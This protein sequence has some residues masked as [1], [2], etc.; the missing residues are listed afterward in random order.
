MPELYGR[1]VNHSIVQMPIHNRKVTVRIVHEPEKPN[2]NVKNKMHL[3]FRMKLWNF[4]N[5]FIL[6]EFYSKFAT[7]ADYE[8]K[9]LFFP[10]K[11]HI[12]YESE[13]FSFFSRVLRQTCNNTVIKIFEFRIVRILSGQLASKRITNVRVEWMIFLP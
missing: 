13:K 7:F 5:F 1:L 3:L 8:K 9:N 12:A 2:N 11:K 4:P 10:Q 6:H